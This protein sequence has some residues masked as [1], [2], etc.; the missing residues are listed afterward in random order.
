M[1]QNNTRSMMKM[2]PG[3]KNF[4]PQKRRR[5]M[6]RTPKGTKLV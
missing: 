4:K 2:D 3:N 1:W 6:D 5:S